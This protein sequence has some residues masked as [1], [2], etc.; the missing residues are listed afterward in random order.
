MSD[1]RIRVEVAYARPEKQKIIELYVAPGTTM[2]EAARLSGIDEHF[3]EI[4]FDSMPMGI[5]GKAEK[6]PDR[7]E[8]R[9]GE[10]VEIY[11]PLKIDPKQVRRQR[12]E[13]SN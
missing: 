3:P 13:K 7:R 9:E 6:M 4:D 11:R 10:R 8:L 2:R 1:E 5:F 12:A